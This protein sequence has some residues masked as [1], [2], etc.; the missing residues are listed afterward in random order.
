MI[1]WWEIFLVILEKVDGN[2]F[3]FFWVETARISVGL[4]EIVCTE[5]LVVWFWR[6]NYGK[7]LKE[8][9]GFVQE[10]LWDYLVIRLS[11]GHTHWVAASS[12]FETRMPF[13]EWNLGGL[14]SLY[15]DV[16]N[17]LFDCGSL[18]KNIVFYVRKI[19]GVCVVSK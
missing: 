7:F 12:W 1:V 9:W 5:E 3:F 17:V 8:V 6:K 18:W 10:N 19:W 11:R 15:A 4:P 14:K 16:I 13:R 2:V